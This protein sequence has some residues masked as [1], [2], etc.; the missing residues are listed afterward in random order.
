M[1]SVH[2]YANQNRAER[3]SRR[4]PCGRSLRCRASP[5]YCLPLTLGV[6]YL[7]LNSPVGAIEP[8][9]L[10]R[11]LI[12][13][14]G[15]EPAYTNSPAVSD[16]ASG[17]PL[18]ATCSPSHG[19]VLTD[20]SMRNPGDSTPG[21]FRSDQCQ[22]GLASR[23]VL[24]CKVGHEGAARRHGWS[25]FYHWCFQRARLQRR[26]PLRHAHLRRRQRKETDK[27]CPSRSPR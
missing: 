22:G 19:A 24:G 21:R 6:T 26:E 11:I 16:P 25:E 12:R 18:R 7:P 17:L 20:M 14:P 5:L 8:H 9:I 4:L 23:S 2:A 27:T 10:T 13:D 3:V 15:V 1:R